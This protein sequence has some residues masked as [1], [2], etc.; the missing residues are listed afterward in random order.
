SAEGVDEAREVLEEFDAPSELIRGLS[1]RRADRLVAADWL[2]RCHRLARALVRNRKAEIGG[3]KARV[4]HP[5]EVTPAEVERKLQADLLD[6]IRGRFA[7][8]DR[9][10]R[11]AVGLVLVAF[12]K[13]L[14]SSSQALAGSLESRRDRLQGELEGEAPPHSSDDPD[15]IEQ[16]RR[17]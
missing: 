1:G 12:Q 10:K 9:T 17:L 7:S 14:C 15:L 3:F 13:M 11:T 16:E 6:Y 8:A 4:A 2:S 5:V